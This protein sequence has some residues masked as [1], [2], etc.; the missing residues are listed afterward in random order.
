MPTATGAGARSTT[1]WWPAEIDAEKKAAAAGNGSG[2]HPLALIGAMRDYMPAD[3]IYV[4]ETIT[5]SQPLQQHL[6]WTTPQSYFRVGGGLGQGTGYALGV[7]LAS[8]KRP[9]ALVVGD[10][11][12]LY[13]PI[14]QAFGASRG[15][16]LPVMIFVMNNRKYA[17]MQKGHLH[18]YPD[19]VAMGADMYHGVHIDGPDYAELAKP[20]GLHGQKVEKVGELKS[21]IENGLKAVKDGRTAVLNVCLTQ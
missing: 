21:A 2:I 19:G 4:E 17:A 18:H 13:N 10:G 3:T 8:P 7:K 6:P 20:F 14:V 11:S 15:N 5:H 1:R 12:F 16:N 9:V